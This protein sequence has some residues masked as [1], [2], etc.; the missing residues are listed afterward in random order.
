MA[1]HYC[2]KSK[3]PNIFKL[4]IIEKVSIRNRCKATKRCA[5]AYDKH[6]AENITLFENLIIT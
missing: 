1:L 4:L 2:G 5:T 3:K 6:T